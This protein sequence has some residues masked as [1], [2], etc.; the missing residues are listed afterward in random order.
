MSPLALANPALNPLQA[1]YLEERIRRGDLSPRQAEQFRRPWLTQLSNPYLLPDINPA[2][3]LLKS[4]LKREDK[5]LIYIFGDKD[6]DGL[7]SAA[8]L[9][10]FLRDIYPP[11]KI[12]VDSPTA[13]DSYG[14]SDA[15]CERI[16]EARPGL[17]ISL[18]CGTSNATEI[19]R[20][21]AAGLEVLV[22]DHHTV[23]DQPVDALLI[24][25]RLPDSRF[26]ADFMAT[27][28]LVVYFLWA[29]F[30]SYTEY[31]HTL[32][33]LPDGDNLARTDGSENGKHESAFFQLVYQGSPLEGKGT[34]G[35]LETLMERA[36]ILIQET[37]ENFF[38]KEAQPG[39]IRL[40]LDTRAQASQIPG[41]NENGGQN[42]PID[43][44]ERWPQLRPEILCLT[45]QLG[46]IASQN[47]FLEESIRQELY[48]LK[49]HPDLESR[50]RLLRFVESA[51]RPALFQRLLSLFDLSAIGTVADMVPLV[52][53][54][55]ILVRQGLEALRHSR[56]PGLRALREQLNL[57]P[58]DLCFRHLGWDFGPIL[59]SP[60]RMQ[61]V[62]L[63]R[64]L[65]LARN[66]EEARLWA[67]DIE[68]LNKER[69]QRTRA[70][71]ELVEKRLA[72]SEI[73]PQADP[74]LVVF[75]PDLAPGVTGL[76]ASR[77]ATEFEKPVALLGPENGLIKGSLRTDLPVDIMP[78]LYDL[79]PFLLECGGHP[80]A[81]GFT[82]DPA[83]LE[84][85]RQAWRERFPAWQALLK[86]GKKNTNTAGDSVLLE[87]QE[88]TPEF[89]AGLEFLEPFGP[90]NP[91]P[92]FRLERVI[93]QSFRF[94]GQD[95][96]HGKFMAAGK[97]GIPLDFVLWQKAAALSDTLDQYPAL[98]VTGQ[99]SWNIFRRRRSL[100][101]VIRDYAGR[102]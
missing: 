33:V 26:P 6:V 17:L 76:V 35:E 12:R 22:I 34:R 23:P 56:R 1:N 79:S 29:F 63:A 89:M 45:E 58:E 21:R 87:I 75:E 72:D 28:G 36:S 37:P 43:W 44:T 31:H 91:E 102:D 30:L 32:F 49:H 51:R 59:N 46:E 20:F 60:G 97:K 95:G 8:L 81:A 85:L 9:A 68:E 54:N 99:L 10:S 24:N 78:L 38:P 48:D 7:S 66:P 41:L 4:F 80:Q 42:L 94:M 40:V 70:N 55:R 93:P 16:L 67:R 90:G 50:A 19:E 25:P 92:F 64:D 86:E 11:E 14:L 98:D 61:K 84:E 71:Q 18:D 77:L 5:P 57:R 53:D 62:G 15:V 88:I 65:L 2:V 27:A 74:V 47:S 82:V 73:S 83:K 96:R 13:A 101:F 39:A 100:Q 52:G 3:D 69:R